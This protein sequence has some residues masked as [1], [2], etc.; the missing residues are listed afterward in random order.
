MYGAGAAVGGAY[1]IAAAQSLAFLVFLL[2]LILTLILGAFYIWKGKTRFTVFLLSTSA[3]ACQVSLLHWLWIT[4]DVRKTLIAPVQIAYDAKVDLRFGERLD[5]AVRTA[6]V[7]ETLM[8]KEGIFGEYEKPKVWKEKKVKQLD[9]Y[10]KGYFDIGNI[11]IWYPRRASKGSIELKLTVNETTVTFLELRSM[12]ASP[13]NY[14]TSGVEFEYPVTKDSRRNREIFLDVY[15][16]LLLL[17]FSRREDPFSKYNTTPTPKDP[18]LFTLNGHR[19]TT[20]YSDTVGGLEAHVS[21]FEH[22]DGSDSIVEVYIKDHELE[23]LG[24][25]ARMNQETPH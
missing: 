10:R 24:R 16:K 14:L 22:L 18:K 19:S 17:G 1:A 12:T 15:E 9:R 2:F 5:E 25:E 11:A 21:L 6:I 13:S 8:Q 7:Y 4:Y 3:L 20:L 23:R